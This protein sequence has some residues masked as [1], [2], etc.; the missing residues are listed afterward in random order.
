MEND[1]IEREISD[2]S[3]L[4][5]EKMENEIREIKKMPTELFDAA[6]NKIRNPQKEAL[7][8]YVRTNIKEIERLGQEEKKRVLQNYENMKIGTSERIHNSL[9]VERVPGGYIFCHEIYDNHVTPNVIG[10]TTTFVPNNEANNEANKRI[11]EL[12]EKV[13]RLFLLTGLY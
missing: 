8:N 7:S 1:F 10:L 11:E 6:D 13:K 3:D 12:E 5:P 4:F 9:Y 2:L